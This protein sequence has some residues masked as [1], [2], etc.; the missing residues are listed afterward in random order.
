MKYVD[1]KLAFF[2]LPLTASYYF[3]CPLEPRRFTVDLFFVVPGL[4]PEASYMLGK[5][6]APELH[7]IFFGCLRKVLP[8]WPGWPWTSNH[9]DS[10]SGVDEIAVLRL[11]VY[12][13]P[14]TYSTESHIALCGT[15][16]AP[17]ACCLDCS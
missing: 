7:P 15:H 5:C 11:Q 8:R 2:I 13:Y 17:H 12:M 16:Q 10:A 1:T 9:A 4:E 6:C 3:R 14:T